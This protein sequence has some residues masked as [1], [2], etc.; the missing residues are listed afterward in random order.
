MN[1]LPPSS[2]RSITA[3]MLWCESPATS[4]ASRLKRSTTSVCVGEPLVQHLERHRALEHAVV[5]AE[6]ARH[7]S[8]ADELLE[9]VPFRDAR[10]RPSMSATSREGS[11]AER[12]LERLF[13]GAERLLELGVGDHE[14]HEHADRSCRGRRR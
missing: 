3:T 5:G 14:R 1:G 9:L 6:D 12:R 7:A 10:R 4:F 2:P 11:L 13:P 8:G